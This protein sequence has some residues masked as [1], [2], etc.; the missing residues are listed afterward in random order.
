MHVAYTHWKSVLNQKT[1][2]RCEGEVRGDERGMS[3][4]SCSN[5]NKE[6]R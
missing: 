5:A 2:S 1:V 4:F 3:A 6:A